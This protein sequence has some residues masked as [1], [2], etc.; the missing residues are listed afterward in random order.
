MVR[1]WEFFLDR[2]QFTIVLM[3][4]LIAAGLYA[5][6]VIPKESAPEVEIPVGIVSVGLPGASAEDVEQL[7]INKLEDEIQTVENIDILSSTAREG[8]GSVVAQFL[9]SAELD[10]SIE[11]LKD[12]VD[13]AKPF[14]PNDATEPV[15]TRI[16][17]ADQPIFIISISTDLPLPEVARFTDEV[18]DELKSVSGVSRVDASGVQ[19]REISVIVRKDALA[20]YNLRIVDIVAAVRAANASLPVGSITSGRV[21]YSV[22]LEA[23]IE[24]SF[25]LGAVLVGNRNG[26]PVYLRDVAD[27]VDGVEEPSTFSRVSIDGDPSAQAL[28]FYV[29]KKSG[30]DV[31]RIGDEVKQKLEDLKSDLLSNSSVLISFDSPDLVRKDI[32]EL[33]QVGLETVILVMLSLFVTIG[34]RESVVAG[35]SIPLSFVIAFIGLYASGNTINQLRFP[36][37]T[38]PIGGYLG[39]LRHRSYRSHPYP[40][41]KIW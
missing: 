7:I 40:L 15:I 3:V 21:E 37:R 8:G 32:R 31:T 28:T 9:A 38:Q 29:F 34:W 11:D 10:K 13:R 30:G 25:D 1:F 22:K 23:D 26:I 4:G 2:K 35:L 14:L 27:I 5:L 36:I 24:D 18:K 6:T 16:N 19:A 20:S 33:S 39:R 17:F 12:A 41:Q